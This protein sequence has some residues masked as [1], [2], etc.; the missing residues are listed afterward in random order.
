MISL[1]LLISVLVNKLFSV[2]QRKRA[3]G[4]CYLGMKITVPLGSEKAR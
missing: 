4:R 1:S 3:T 2:F